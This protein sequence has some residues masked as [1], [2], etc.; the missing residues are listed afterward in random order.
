MTSTLAASFKTAFGAKQDM[1]NRLN[2]KLTDMLNN[3]HGFDPKT[4]ALMK[5]GAADTVSRQTDAAQTAASTYLATHGGPTLGSGVAAQIHGGIAAAGATEGSRESSNI[6][7][8]SGLLQNDNY[9]KAISGLTNVANSENPEGLANAE[10]GSADATANL[11][12]AYLAS[13]QADWQNTFGIIKGVAGLASAAVPMFAGVGA[14]GGGGSNPNSPS[15]IGVGGDS[16]G[17]YD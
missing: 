6:D 1:L 8:Q 11:S 7:I 14:G 3:P 13:K 2:A 16:T 4:L 15:G 9:W 5:S 12:K 17:W 10:V